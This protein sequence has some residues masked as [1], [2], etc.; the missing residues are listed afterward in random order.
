M[1]PK[2]RISE[3]QNVRCDKKPFTFN[4]LPFGISNA[5]IKRDDLEN[6]QDIRWSTN[7]PKAEG[8]I[9]SA[10]VEDIRE[11]MTGNAETIVLDLEEVPLVDLDVVRFVGV[12]EAEGVELVN[13][14]PYI[15]DWIFRE[16]NTEDR[17]YWGFLA[18]IVVT[19][20]ATGKTN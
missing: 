7:N 17:D 13:Y 12:S 15:R 18:Q 1:T 20:S 16:R 3:P 14:S 9:Q 8:R 4:P 11:Q 10:N 5:P 2:I 6:R 19:Q